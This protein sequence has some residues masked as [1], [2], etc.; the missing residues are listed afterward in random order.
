MTPLSP[1]Y[2]LP[3][4]GNSRPAS[5]SAGLGGFRPPSYQ[6]K[7]RGGIPSRAG[8]SKV[9]IDARGALSS[10]TLLALALML[11]G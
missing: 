3:E 2:M 1:M 8:K 4:S 9:T 10:K 5:N 6:I 11:V 7:R